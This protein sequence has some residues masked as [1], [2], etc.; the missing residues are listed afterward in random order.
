M[1]NRNDFQ[2]NSKFK[3]GDPSSERNNFTNDTVNIQIKPEGTK[4][5]LIMVDLQNDFCSGTMA[6]ED[7]HEIIPLI[8]QLKNL[9]EKFDYYF[10]TRD[11]HPSNHI[12]FNS[13]HPGHEMFENIEI[14]ET[15]LD[16]ILW[17]EHC[18]QKSHGADYID[19]F[20]T[21]ENDIEIFK[22]IK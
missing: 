17:P 22:G 10:T 15:G 13:S 19:G 21:N 11:W 16:Q 3:S 6:V 20:E 7:A 14:E 1:K 8:N 18:I 4:S 5:A 9:D 2:V 12:S